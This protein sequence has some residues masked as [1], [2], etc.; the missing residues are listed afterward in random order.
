MIV[1]IIRITGGNLRLLDGLPTQ[2]EQ[3]REIND[4][5]RVTRAAVREGLVIGQ[6]WS[7]EMQSGSA[8]DAA[9]TCRPIRAGRD[10]SPVRRMTS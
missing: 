3:D 1:A 5:A 9:G 8:G 4:L 6:A 10:V 7:V 2:V